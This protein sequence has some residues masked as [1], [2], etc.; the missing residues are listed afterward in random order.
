M[1]PIYALCTS[2]VPEPFH[3]YL[4]QVIL[5]GFVYCIGKAKNL[6]IFCSYVYC[7]CKAKFFLLIVLSCSFLHAEPHVSSFTKIWFW[8][9]LCSQLCQNILILL[10]YAS[11]FALYFFLVSW[12]VEVL[13]ARKLKGWWDREENY[14][15]IRYFFPR[16]AQESSVL[17]SR[18]TDSFCQ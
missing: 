12:R 17:L 16:T 3:I 1:L 6:V 2:V 15:Q 11:L 8:A 10:T 13:V 5:C 9:Y 4:I 14:K 7:I 18:N